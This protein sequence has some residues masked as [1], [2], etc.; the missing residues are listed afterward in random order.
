MI[1]FKNKKVR[2]QIQGVMPER[3]L[4]R[5]RRAEI[6]LFN[7]K[8]PQPTRIIF[9]VK[10]KDV[11]RVLAIYPSEES[12]ERSYASYTVARLPATGVEKCLQTLKKRWGI[13]LGLGLFCLVTLYADNFV[14]GV[15][16][17]GS[18]AY[19]REIYTAL[20]E[21]DIRPFAKYSTEKQDE[22]CAKM[23]AL[24]GVEFCSVQKS[25][26]WAR[27]EMRLGSFAEAK[28]Q[29]GKMHAKYT[30]EVVAITALRGVPVKKIG[31]KI[32]AGEM[33]VNDEVSVENGGQVRVE[34][35]ARVQ[36][37]CVYEALVCADDEESAFAA[38]YLEIGADGVE[39]TE[40]SVTQKQENTYAVRLF[41][42]ATQ[43][44]NL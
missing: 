41:Y 5:L 42:T 39:L 29:K 36:I 2:L 15:E 22:F 8:K 43:T 23:L 17:V 19:A 20:D 27:V 13:V 34:I 26:L 30:G 28:I 24:D 10:S 25:G 12:A 33:L 14:F 4:L 7:I 32:T 11:E 40:K 35:I 38:A 3:A 31:D 9:C 37:A 44:M 18:E 21:A 1:L 6:P 16:I